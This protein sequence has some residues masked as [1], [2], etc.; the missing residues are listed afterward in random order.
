MI[1]GEEHPMLPA[2][3]EKPSDSEATPIDC[4]VMV[5]PLPKVTVSVNSVP[6]KSPDPYVT[7]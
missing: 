3:L 2:T 6:E 1:E 5:R 4:L 7:A